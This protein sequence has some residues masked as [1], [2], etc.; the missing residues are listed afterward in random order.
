ML[1]LDRQLDAG[2]DNFVIDLS[3]DH[4]PR[5]VRKPDTDKPLRFWATADLLHKLQDLH[6]ALQAGTSPAQLGLTETARTGESLELL[7]HLQH[8]WAS[9]A[10]REQRRAPRESVKRLVDV[11][12]GLNALIGQIKTAEAPASVSP[13]GIGLN[14][15]EEDDVQ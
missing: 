11:T 1:R 4:G 13:Y 15:T 6:T 8:Q 5:R 14:Y 12:H 9:L 7:E 3:A 2:T 10:N